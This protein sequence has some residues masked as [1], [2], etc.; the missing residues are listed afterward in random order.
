MSFKYLVIIYNK[1]SGY[2]TTIKNR[3]I[4]LCPPPKKMFQGYATAL[5]PLKRHIYLKLVFFFI[6][7]K[8]CGNA[9]INLKC[10]LKRY[11]YRI[12]HAYAYIS[13]TRTGIPFILQII[14]FRQFKI[15]SILWYSNIL[16]EYK[17]FSVKH[18][19]T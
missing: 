1:V 7:K 15:R 2:I 8:L 11:T 13:N 6:V 4:N 19:P 17:Y 9:I 12:F 14:T 5:H 3:A 10:L 16:F 18:T